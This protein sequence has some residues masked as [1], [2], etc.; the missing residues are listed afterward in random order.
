MNVFTTEGSID[1]AAGL[2]KYLGEGLMEVE[3]L[4]PF[5]C[6][7]PGML[8]L[9]ALLGMGSPSPAVTIKRPKETT[10]SPRLSFSK[11]AFFW[12]TARMLGVEYTWIRFEARAGK[13]TLKRLS[14]E[15]RLIE[16]TI[17]D[18]DG[19]LARQYAQRLDEKQWIRISSG[20][21][22]SDTWDSYHQRKRRVI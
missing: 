6:C 11:A 8:V 18:Q 14:M 12:P 5:I 13:T 3:K 20:P 9:C 10:I 22:N 7:V 17:D 21:V 2:V 4:Y 1:W 15:G 19:D 16:K